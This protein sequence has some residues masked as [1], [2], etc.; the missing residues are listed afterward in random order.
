MNDPNGL[1]FYHGRYHVFY[2]HY[3]YKP[4]WGP[5]HW[6][7][8]SSTDMI[9]WREEPIALKPDQ[10]YDYH[11]KMGGC[12]SGSAIVHNDKLFLLYTGCVESMSPYQMQ[13]LAASEDGVHFNKYEGNPVI[14]APPGGCSEDFRDP[15]VWRKDGRFYCV[16]GSQADGIGQVLLY[17][18]DNL[19]Q[20]EYMGVMARGDASLG[21]M[22]ECPDLAVFDQYDVLIY[23]P[24]EALEG[25]TRYITGRL[26]YNSGKLSDILHGRVDYGIDFYAPQTFLDDSGRRIMIG[27]LCSWNTILPSQSYGW[28]GQLSIPRELWV[29]D[30]GNLFQRPVEELEELRSDYRTLDLSGRKGIYEI[31]SY[32]DH[33]YELILSVE[34]EEASTFGLYLRSSSDQDE[35]TKLTVDTAKNALIF[36]RTRSGAGEKG[37]YSAPILPDTDGNYRIRIFVDRNSIELFTTS[38]QTAMSF[39]IYPSYESNHL[40]Y[41]SES[42]SDLKA[43]LDLWKLDSKLNS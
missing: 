40:L 43:S 33:Q 37:I 23:S 15:K 39:T 7:H 18:S 2:Q 8:F 5:M 41:F 32:P 11:E 38:Y 1:V 36:D 26:D 25:K 29:D 14:S 30:N 17:R 35:T 16:I 21:N 12:F 27:W 24:I 19:Y 34:P 28:A 20:W 22:W 13:A 9:H 42:P 10:S 4:V 6:G 31:G 3:P